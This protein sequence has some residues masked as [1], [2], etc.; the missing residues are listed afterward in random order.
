MQLGPKRSIR[1]MNHFT[2]VEE[3]FDGDPRHVTYRTNR[4]AKSTI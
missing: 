4:F 3:Y 2:E 1:S